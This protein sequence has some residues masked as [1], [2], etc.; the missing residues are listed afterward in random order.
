[1]R[2]LKKFLVIAP[3]LALLGAFLLGV[4]PA[5]AQE[6]RLVDLEL[7]ISDRHQA[8]FSGANFLVSVRN[9]SDVTVRDIRVQLEVEDVALGRSIFL[10]EV[11]S[12]DTPDNDGTVNYDTL[13]WTIPTLRGARTATTKLGV[14]PV[15]TDPG[16]GLTESLLVR[17]QGR[18]VESVPSEAPTSLSMSNSQARN[19]YLYTPDGN[20]HVVLSRESLVYGVDADAATD[21]FAVRVS[22]RNTGS[23]HWQRN[24]PSQ[25]QVRL[26]V[27][28]SEGLRYTATPPVGT[29][30]DAA[31]GI[32]DIGTLPRRLNQE[33]LRQLDIR[34]TGRDA[35]AGP[36]EEQCLTV[37]IEHKIPDPPASWLPVTAC[38]AHKALITQG[39]F[40]VF[41]WHDCVSDSDYPCSSQPSLELT[42]IKRGFEYEDGNVVAY[43]VGDVHRARFRTDHI[44]SNANDMILQPE[45]ALLRVPDNARTRKTESGNTVWSTVGLYDLFIY[46]DRTGFLGGWSDLRESVTVSGVDGAGLPGRWRMRNPNFDFFDATDSMKVVGPTYQPSSIPTD[47]TTELRIE[48][49][50]LGTYVAL[51]EIEGT[52]TG[53]KYTDSGAYTFHVG[54]VAELE[55]SA[56]GQTP[57]GGV[58]IT[59]V[60]NGPDHSQGARA[61]L[62]SGQSCDFGGVFPP[63]DLLRLSGQPATHTCLI[64]DVDLTEAQ[65]VGTEPIGHIENHVDYTVCIDSNGRD[66]LPKP[67]GESACQSEG[68]T[69]HVVDVYDYI[70]GNN[71]IFLSQDQV[72]ALNL[73]RARAREVPILVVRWTRL[74]EMF[75]SPVSWY[76]VE[77]LD[78]AEWELLGNVPQPESGDPEYQDG[79]EDRA[80]SPRYRVRA[81]NDEGIAGPWAEAGGVAQPGV[82]LALDKDTIK[83]PDDPNNPTQ[84]S[85]ATV[86]ASLT[87]R[88]SSQDIT[89]AVSATPDDPSAYTLSDNRNLVIPAGM[90]ESRGVVTITAQEDGDGD[91]EQ[92]SITAVAAYTHGAI[93]PLT[94][95]I[96]DKNDPGLTLNPYTLMVTEYDQTGGTYTVK[97][98]AAPSGDVTVTLTSNNAD[99]TVDPASLTFT[100]DNW[101]TTQTV[102]VRA[103]ADND[104]ANDTATIT[105]RTSGP[106]GYGNLTATATVTVDDIDTPAVIVEHDSNLTVM[107]DGRTSVQYRV[108][109][110]T[111]PSGTDSVYIT[112]TGSDPDAVS[113]SPASF[114]LTRSNWER[115]QTVTVQA[116][117]DQDA[118]YETVNITH[119]IDAGRTTADEYDGV[120]IAGMVTVRV[121]DA[122]APADYDTEDDNGGDGLLEITT[123][124]QLNAIRWDLDGN[125]VAD[126]PANAAAY[127][128]AFPRMMANSCGASFVGGV[129]EEVS[130]GNGPGDCKGYELMNGITL[131][132]NWTP[133]GGNL[134]F[135]D[136]DTRVEEHDYEATFDGNGNVIRN[137]RVNRSDGKYVGLFGATGSGAFIRNVGLENANVE[138]RD[139]LGALVGRNDGGRIERAWSTGRVS[140]NTFTGGLVGWN[141][142]GTVAQSYSEANVS[143]WNP[144]DSGGPL[145]S[146]RI[147]GLVGANHGKI[148][149]SYAAGEARGRGHVAGL[150]GE[151]VGTIRNSYSTGAV[152]T[153]EDWPHKGG[154]VG[155]QLGSVENSYW[156]TVRSGQAEA[157]AQGG[158]PDPEKDAAQYGKTTDELQGPTGAAGIYANWTDIRE[159]AEGNPIRDAEGN[160]IDVWNFRGASE[161]P[162]LSGV[163]SCPDPE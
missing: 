92:V 37:E 118:D 35:R 39:V 48:F 46:Q 59:A 76:Q 5:G 115:G 3:A 154:L 13:E 93:R 153:E 29:T 79:D 137:L 147:A 149:N 160:P 71:E 150:A 105:H 66:V 133:I 24:S 33:G 128:R 131:S 32:W 104:A 122:Q 96:D 163:G 142:G 18:I 50:A 7:S 155:W 108:R 74:E 58:A 40:D 56:A 129:S 61:V 143:G 14:D 10:Q 62:T 64:P 99:V 52:K 109:L 123:Q 27:T 124:E 1:M 22:N 65:L 113:I 86:T 15:R 85:I 42:A 73:Q 45:E 91:N 152:S 112:V 139:N 9:R 21:T 126:D 162:C 146:T 25:Y 145:W 77:R 135:D 83:E 12:P 94:L 111:E 114:S 159:D 87:G 75:G 97:L 144:S 130:P 141:R 100:A 106:S 89:I 67:D 16:V 80:A 30:F 63:G 26:K 17:L 38:M 120:S 6:Q 78:G 72:P 117:A 98:D 140:G 41:S 54:P 134:R 132:G 8:L 82:V 47:N 2:I 81:V 44:I 116:R 121:I 60:N 70:D 127:A 119:A 161:Y 4:P 125:G 43:S 110:D 23:A 158:D 156:D 49:G 102:T 101:Q 95:T 57:D 151:N 34:V 103:D 53:T 148:E 55:V 136:Y 36:A 69:W 68:G 88:V 138:G 51:F 11:T 107:E 31:T 90:R 20:R 28:T 84:A 19:F 157:F